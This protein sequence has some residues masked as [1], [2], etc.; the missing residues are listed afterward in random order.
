[1]K[2]RKEPTIAEL[3]TWHRSIYLRIL[4]NEIEFMKKLK[5]DV[6]HAS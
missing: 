3:W 2:K 5:K 4:K 1:M 6:S